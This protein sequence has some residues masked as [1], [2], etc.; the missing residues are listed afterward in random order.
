MQSA[1]HMPH[2]GLVPSMPMPPYPAGLPGAPGMPSAT[3][4]GLMGLAGVP[5]GLMGNSHFHNLKDEMGKL[6][7]TY[8]LM[9][10]SMVFNA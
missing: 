10:T 3:A 1:Q 2:A 9:N 4:A 8:L 5:G 7:V 6:R